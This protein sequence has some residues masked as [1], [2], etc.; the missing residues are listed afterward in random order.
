MSAEAIIVTCMAEGNTR[1]IRGAL[2]PAPT[3]ASHSRSTVSRLAA[4]LTDAL[5]AW[6]TRSLADL[7]VI[8][9]YLVG[10]APRVCS[11]RQGGQRADAGRRGRPHCSL[12]FVGAEGTSAAGVPNSNAPMS[13]AD[14]EY[15]HAESRVLKFG[16]MTPL[17]R[18][19]LVPPIRNAVSIK[20]GATLSPCG[21]CPVPIRKAANVL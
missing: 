1:R 13:G 15:G 5:A 17:S 7:D 11:A 16:R 6:R 14:P 8:Y 20:S 4:T 3:E 2:Q 21:S 18:A 10:F 9:V 12:R 19:G